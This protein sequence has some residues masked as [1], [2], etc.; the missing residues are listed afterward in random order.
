PVAGWAARLPRHCSSH[1]R[2]RSGRSN[3]TEILSAAAKS[4][5]GSL[6]ALDRLCERYWYPLYAFLRRSGHG[7]EQAEDHV[8]S[9]FEELLRRRSWSAADPSRGRFR[10]FLLTACQNHVRKRHRSDNALKRGGGETTL[11][12]S[13]ESGESR[14]EREP[15]VDDDP[16]RVFDRQWAIQMIETALQRLTDEMSDSGRSE[17]FQEFRPFFAPGSDTPTYAEVAQRLQISENNVK[18][19][20]HRLRKKFAEYL[21]DEVAGTVSEDEV[22]S[23]IAELIA[24]V[25]GY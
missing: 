7:P 20:V 17:R 11:S 14:F 6:E 8:Q 10:T 18:V 25:S 5:S 24:A 21:Q 12:I 22:E 3:W 13:F 23:E 1:S 15:V 4:D 16:S 19:A 9:F 2:C